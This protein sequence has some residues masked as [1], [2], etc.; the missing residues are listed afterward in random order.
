M[1]L[2]LIEFYTVD[3]DINFAWVNAGNREVALKALGMNVTFSECI[4]ITEQNE[5]VKLLG[6]DKPVYLQA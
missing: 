2:Y 4:Q 5:I 3:E 6:V 1:N